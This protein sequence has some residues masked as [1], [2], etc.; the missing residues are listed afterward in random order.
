MKKVI[1]AL[2][3]V[4][5]MFS[6][7]VPVSADNIAKYEKCVD[8][9][10]VL[11][12]LNIIDFDL[13][14][15]SYEGLISRGN[16]I[17]MTS[18]FMTDDVAEY[19]NTANTF[20][21][22][23]PD[24]SCFAAVN[25]AQTKGILDNS[26]N[27]YP[28]R[29]IDYNEAAKFLVRL[30]GYSAFVT[31]N[32]Y[33][34]KASELKITSGL[35]VRNGITYGDAI[36]MLYN[37]LDV[38]IPE[39]DSFSTDGYKLKYEKKAIEYYRGI[40]RSTGIVNQIYFCAVN[41]EEKFGLE[42]DEI[43]IG[44]EVYKCSYTQPED[45]FGCNT[46]FW[47]TTDDIVNTI[48]YI[49][50]YKNRRIKV[51]SDDFS[52]YTGSNFT[53]YEG[54][55]QKYIKISGNVDVI[56]NWS[57]CADYTEDDILLT[58]LTGNDVFIDND[59]DGIY[60]LIIINE[61]KDF[62]VSG[63]DAENKKIYTGQSDVIIDGSKCD[64]MIII[65][66]EKGEI[67]LSAIDSDGVI[68][69]QQSKATAAKLFLRVYNSNNIKTGVISN[70]AEE[71]RLAVI[72]G[73]IYRVNSNAAAGIY[74]GNMG[75][76][77]IDYFGYIGYSDYQGAELGRIYGFLMRMWIDEDSE[78]IN[79][80]IINENGEIGTYKLNNKVTLDGIRRKAR[81]VY[82]MLLNTA[83]IMERQ[84]VVY[85]LSKD[86]KINEIDTKT[87]EDGESEE[88]ELK[89][90]QYSNTSWQRSTATK[91]NCIDGKYGF[92]RAAK[93]FIIPD[94]SGNEKLQD[95]DCRVVNTYDVPKKST[96][97]KLDV[98]DPDDVGMA[99]IGV[100]YY[101]KSTDWRVGG[102]ME[103]EVYKNTGYYMVYSVRNELSEDNEVKPVLYYFS[104]GT[105]CSA[106]VEN[107]NVIKKPVYKKSLAEGETDWIE[108]NSDGTPKYK[109]VQRGDI[110]Q[111]KADDRGIITAAT[112]INDYERVDNG[113]FVSHRNNENASKQYYDFDFGIVYEKAGNGIGVVAKLKDDAQLY[114]PNEP[115]KTFDIVEQPS[116]DVWKA[117]DFKDTGDLQE[118]QRSTVHSIRKTSPIIIYDSENKE[119]R[120]GFID[121]LTDCKSA[122]K[123]PSLVLVRTAPMYRCIFVY[124]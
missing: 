54:G 58:G 107:E 27:F 32:N 100:Y 81:N 84:V 7:I 102:D 73:E 111:F 78:E 38:Y 45:V 82:A 95:E 34:K 105:I 121:D 70:W 72:D 8:Q 67:D 10:N 122:G 30:T 12:A 62:T 80:K 97:V 31:D 6:V 118:L 19:V 101:P 23:A 15:D 11:R 36:S 53:Y 79:A 113:R 55:R 90:I 1:S 83:G 99:D 37:C 61:Y 50:E 74:P 98:V 51:Q 124:K 66:S 110:I 2:L 103:Y 106:K 85:K 116:N 35:N 44:N 39:K 94:I 48:L 57:Y 20:S 123:N 93:I 96:R 13:D 115:E 114:N 117:Y 17:K 9:A 76:F 68:S 64:N 14:E 120:Y 42:Q 59:N 89:V 86:G 108:R 119:I 60:D 69:V 3:A 52:K 16:F 112:I 33:A 77:Y 26:E 22:V 87:H 21:D 47:Y 88:T 109:L 41:G 24:S 56:Y 43:V 49:G 29:Y 75:N 40:K 65:D 46:E 28:D 4:I 92:T 104:N 5:T 18:G 91:T 71:D 25:C 63:V